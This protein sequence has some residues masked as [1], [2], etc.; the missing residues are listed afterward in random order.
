V[1][2]ID[3]GFADKFVNDDGS[4]VSSKECVDTFQGNMLFASTD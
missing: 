2:L 1:T 4:H 3:Y